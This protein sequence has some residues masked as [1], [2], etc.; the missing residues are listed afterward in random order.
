M[1]IFICIFAYLIIGFSFNLVI[2]LVCKNF[3]SFS[4]ISVIGD[5]DGETFWLISNILLWPLF[6]F[7]IILAD[8]IPFLIKKMYVLFVA[9]IF[10]IV[11]LFKK[12]G[13]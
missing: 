11:A 10:G 5:T 1:V 13:K 7:A 4:I 9:I 2:S 3:D 8:F 6:L 12:E